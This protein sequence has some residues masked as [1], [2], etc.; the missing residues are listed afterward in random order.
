[1][2]LM[3]AFQ[4]A[5]AEQ[6]GLRLYPL[7]ASDPSQWDMRVEEPAVQ[8]SKTFLEGKPAKR[9]QIPDEQLLKLVETDKVQQPKVSQRPKCNVC[10]VRFMTATEEE[11]HEKSRKHRAA[12]RRLRSASL[13]MKE[14]D[15]SEKL[16]TYSIS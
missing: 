3:P 8:I 5:V 7:D 1:M 16:A 14:L 2:K 11:R 13:P 9:N 15:N 6:D 10:G 12:L 4:R